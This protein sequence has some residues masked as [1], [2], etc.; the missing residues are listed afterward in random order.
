MRGAGASCAGDLAVIST[1]CTTK[2][3]LHLLVIFP[4]LGGLLGSGA[5]PGLEMFGFSV[6]D[7]EGLVAW[8]CGAWAIGS[9]RPVLLLGVRLNAGRRVCGFGCGVFGVNGLQFRM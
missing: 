9:E 7:A 6:F 4:G 8:C 2:S 3:P 1:P 5:A